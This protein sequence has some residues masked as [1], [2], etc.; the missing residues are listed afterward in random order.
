MASSNSAR[1]LLLRESGV[2]VVTESSQHLHTVVGVSAASISSRVEVVRE[3]SGELEE[4]ILLYSG[5]I[6]DSAASFRRE[7]DDSFVGSSEP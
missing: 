1:H 4:R 6:R 3:S 5:S 2:D 7:S